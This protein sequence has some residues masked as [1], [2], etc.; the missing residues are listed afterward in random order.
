MICKLKE[1][2]YERARPVIEGVDHAL[3]VDAVIDGTCPG[4]V[5]VDDVDTPRTLFAETPEGHYLVGYEEN[6][7]FNRSLQELI[8][9]EI[10]PKGEKEGWWYLLV[11]YFPN[12]WEETLDAMFGGRPVVKDY[13]EFYAFRERR[14][15]WREN[16]PSGFCMTRVDRELLERTDLTNINRINGWAEGNFGS[17]EGFVTTGFGFC[18]LHGDEI[19]SWCMADCVSGDR[20][21]VGIHTDERY[22]RR[23]F[24]TLTLAAAVD[25]CL[26]NGLTHIG[27][28]CWSSNSPSAATARKVGF[29]KVLDHHAF[30]IWFNEIDSHLVNGNIA[31]MRE[32]F[33]EAAAWYEKAFR[34]VEARRDATDSHLLVDREDPVRYYYQAASAWALAGER[35]SALRN[36]TRALDRSSLRQGAF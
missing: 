23:G 12:S 17:I 26:S 2:E 15:D 1:S 6:E 29:E 35:E 16:V 30:H 8:V 32:E 4:S 22:R 21:E 20:S 18:L 27:W 7:A 34:I 14:I 31:F 36:V 3:A 33:G 28:H 24:A 25:H 19:V 11:H 9:D 13:Q 5:Y 10:L